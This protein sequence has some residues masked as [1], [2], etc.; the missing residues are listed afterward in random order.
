[1][2]T[3]S[4]L[5]GDKWKWSLRLHVRGRIESCDGAVNIVTCNLLLLHLSTVSRELD[6]ETENSVDRLDFVKARNAAATPRGSLEYL[7]VHIDHHSTL[8]NPFVVSQC[9]ES[10]HPHPC[11]RLNSTRRGPSHLLIFPPSTLDLLILLLSNIPCPALPLFQCQTDHPLRSSSSRSFVISESML[12]FESDLSE[13]MV[14][15]P[16]GQDQQAGTFFL[17]FL[18]LMWDPIEGRSLGIDSRFVRSGSCLK[19]LRST[20]AAEMKADVGLLSADSGRELLLPTR[21]PSVRV[22][23]GYS[24]RAVHCT[25][26]LVQLGYAGYQILT[27]VALVNGIDPFAFSIYRNILAFLLLGPVAFCLERY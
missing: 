21:S 1:M 2:F 15:W 9:S 22:G 3:S 4:E 20:T 17:I 13:V 10:S 27:R 18:I 23:N 24:V 14:C 12:I 7:G 16:G 26:A 8:I 11:C 5:R 25:L 6:H 19:G